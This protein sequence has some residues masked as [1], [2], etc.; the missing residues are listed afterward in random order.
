ME[1]V[2]RGS[3][4]TA[5]LV[6]PAWAQL[7][8]A[9]GLPVHGEEIHARRQL[10]AWFAGFEFV[11][12]AAH[13]E[14]LGERLEPALVAIATDAA[15]NV[16]VRARALSSMIYADGAASERVL[17]ALLGDPAAPSILRRKA[18][19]VLAERTG[20]RY[21]DLLVSA[22]G[23]AAGD[24]P[25]REACARALRSMGP[26]AHAARDVLFRQTRAPTVK[27]LLGETKR[28]GGAP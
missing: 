2:M 20:D 17:V 24:L 26:D 12:T 21:L 11:P 3:L 18:A 28:I 9:P 8:D 10:E 19:L 4:W 1:V 25:L 5:L 7:A 16:L 15:A 23:A 6:L 13:F 14:R 27:G 22:F